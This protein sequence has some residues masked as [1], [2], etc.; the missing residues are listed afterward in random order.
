M[1]YQKTPGGPIVGFDIDIATALAKEL[2][3][4]LVVSNTPNFSELIPAVQ[5]NRVDISDSSVHDTTQR[6]SSIHFVDDFSS[7]IQFMG[8]KSKTAK[9]TTHADLCGDTVMVQAGTNYAAKIAEF[10]KSICPAGKP[11]A[12]LG[13]ASPPDEVQQIQIGRAI[14]IA[15]GPESNGYLELTQPG[16]WHLIG[17][18]WDLFKYGIMF[19]KNDAQLGIALRDAL[20]VLIQNGTYKQIL[21]KWDLSGDGVTSATIDNGN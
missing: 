7:G 3:L 6:E 1:E 18:S 5:T 10:S 13:A 21:T 15:E 17:K 2:G 14:A 11:I 4:S 20:T 16:K 19:K 12:T 8:L 9:L